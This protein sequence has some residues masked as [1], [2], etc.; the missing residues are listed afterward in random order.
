MSAGGHT[1]V[2]Q[3]V[4][5]RRA[6]KPPEGHEGT[7]ATIAVMLRVI[8]PPRALLSFS[9]PTLVEHI[10]QRIAPDLLEIEAVADQAEAVQRLNAEFRPVIVTDSLDL[11]RTVRSRSDARAPFI[12]YVADLDD[13]IER[14]AGLTAGADE[15]LGRR[16]S[17]REIRARLSVA[18]RIAELESA[19][20]ITLE[21][22]RKLSAVDELTRTASR[23]FFGEEAP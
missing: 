1:T 20:R 8:P 12:L 10:E 11:I 7:T 5:E 17:E 22:N 4:L 3:R 21:E 19:L 2:I 18:R 9:D 13:S 23:R 16:A 14:E 6:Q 15:C